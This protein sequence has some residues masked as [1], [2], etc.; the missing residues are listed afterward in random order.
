MAYKKKT[1]YSLGGWIKEKDTGLEG[2]IKDLFKGGTDAVRQFGASLSGEAFVPK[3]GKEDYNSKFGKFT[4]GYLQAQGN[5]GGK[6]L[7]LMLDT[8]VAPGSGQLLKGVGQVAYDPNNLSSDSAAYNQSQQGAQDL[9]YQQDLLMRRT[10]GMQQP[11]MNNQSIF[12]YGGKMKDSYALGGSI[13]NDITMYN[14]NKHEQ[15][16][17]SLNDYVEVEDGETRGQGN[18]KDFIFSDRIKFNDKSFAETSKVISNKYK[19]QPNDSLTAF[20]KNRE[21]NNLAY[22]QELFKAD[23]GVRDYTKGVKKMFGGGSLYGPPKDDG[24]W[25][26]PSG[27]YSFDALTG[28]SKWIPDNYN[29]QMGPNDDIAFMNTIGIQRRL[30][31]AYNDKQTNV[32]NNLTGID[33]GSYQ[34]P[35][36]NVPPINI[37]TN[38]FGKVSTP[39]EQV[40]VNNI[41]SKGLP[42]VAPNITD[43]DINRLKS[44]IGTSN[45]QGAPDYSSTPSADILGIGLSAIPNLLASFQ[46]SDLKKNI[47]YGRVGTQTITPQLIDP[48]RAIQDANVGFNR[49]QGYLRQ[50]NLGQGSYLSNMLANETNRGYALS[51]IYGQFGNMNA[52]ISN[53]AQEFNANQAAQSDRIN[54][55]LRMREI[56]DRIGIDQNAISLGTQGLNNATQAYL[57]DRNFRYQAP[58]LGGPNVNVTYG[59]DKFGLYNKPNITYSRG[60]YTTTDSGTNLVPIYKDGK[61]IGYNQE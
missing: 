56:Q 59:K 36:P 11:N 8:M 54:T 38:S 21:L 39:I 55:D 43:T 58:F 53:R 27:R 33:K 57:A 6:A 32:I 34:N 9:Q 44:K 19:N 1:K 7:P 52:D 30:Q 23:K 12:A 22:A 29:P 24:S 46:T 37:N 10:M 18:T 51:G 13:F 15:G 20:A 40:K 17:I 28:K 25:A 26:T 48:T 3:Y 2:Y 50:G 47:N 41:T 42:I 31:N 4:S 49:S 5:I 61:I 16:G 14:G 60:K 45:N 35:G